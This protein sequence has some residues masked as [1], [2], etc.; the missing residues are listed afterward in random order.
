MS[1]QCLHTSF[2]HIL[3]DKHTIA[4]LDQVLSE[5]MLLMQF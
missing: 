2:S 5:E 1:H 3:S 4:E